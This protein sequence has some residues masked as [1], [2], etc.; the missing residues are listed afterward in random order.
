M[1]AADERR[2]REQGWH[3]R[4]GIGGA[5]LERDREVAT[6]DAFVSGVHGEGPRLGLIEGPAGIGKT[7]LLTETRR[8]AASDGIRVLSARGSELE[9]EFP[10]GLVRQ[11]FEPLLA[12]PQVRGGAFADAAAPAEAVFDSAGAQGAGG[13][14]PMPALPASTASTG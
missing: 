11:L 6:L 2:T 12:D 8:L 14:D 9:R 1:R 3:Q 10:Y 4:R 7:T 5:L 13:W